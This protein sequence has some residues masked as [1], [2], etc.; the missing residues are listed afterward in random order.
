MTRDDKFE[1]TDEKSREGGATAKGTLLKGGESRVAEQ[2]RRM[3]DREEWEDVE[4]CK[5]RGVTERRC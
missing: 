4:G 3:I 1:P 5:K 2:G